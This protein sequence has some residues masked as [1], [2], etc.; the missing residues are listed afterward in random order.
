MTCGLREE[1]PSFLIDDIED[2]LP[3]GDED[4]AISDLRRKM[5]TLLFAGQA[6]PASLGD[7]DPIGVPRGLDEVIED[8]TAMN[9]SQCGAIVVRVELDW[10]V[11]HG[12]IA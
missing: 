12:E 8:Q 7:D 1:E 9:M 5:T 4:G 2:V 6:G 3:S 11:G 10:S